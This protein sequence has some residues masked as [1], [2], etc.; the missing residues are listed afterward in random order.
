MRINKT[1]ALVLIAGV[2][3]GCSDSERP[4]T[5]SVLPDSV[6]QAAFGFVRFIT[7]EGVERAQLEADSAYHYPSR[8]SWDLFNMKII[9]RT[10]RGEIRSTLT[11]LHGTYNWRTQ[12]MEARDSVRAVTPDDREL[13]TCAINYDQ[14]RDE[15][16][17]P[18]D[19]VYVAPN[20]RLTGESF[21]ADPDFRNVVAVR[22]TAILTEVERR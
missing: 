6:D 1:A 9:F 17:G 8:D 11:A 13:T 14:G 12:N 3:A 15:I 20:E 18:C 16:T 4:P 7:S 10:A 2:F 21:T 5:S 22:P 19:F